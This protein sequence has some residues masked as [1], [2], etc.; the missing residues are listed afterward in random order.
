MR[1]ATIAKAASV[2][3]LGV[4]TG[5]ITTV[6]FHPAPAGA[7]IH[8]RR[9]DVPRSPEIAAHV[10]RVVDT[11]RSTTLGIGAVTVRTVEHVLAT[12]QC[13]GLDNVLV[14][15]SGPETPLVDGSGVPYVEA[16]IGAGRVEQEG[17]SAVLALERP[18]AVEGEGMTLCAI[19]A[20]EYRISYIMNYDHPVLGTQFKSVAV[21]RETYINEI[22]PA[23]TFCLYREVEQLMDRG[24]IRGGSLDNAV[25]VTDEAVLSKEGLRFEN[26]FVRHKIIDLLGDLSLIGRRLQAHVISIRSGH[27]NN[28]QFARAICAAHGLAT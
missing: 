6:T 15:M 11:Q 25:V 12:L 23:R 28:V 20:A 14:E 9:V 7:G 19:P 21:N 24:L 22:A 26:E 5:G 18:I 4:H 27:A 1:Q 3:G 10:A 2:S 16:L 8:F 17:E 13:L